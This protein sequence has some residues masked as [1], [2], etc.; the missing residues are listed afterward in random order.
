MPKKAH[1]TFRVATHQNKKRIPDF[2]LTVKQ[3]SLIMMQDGYSGHESIIHLRLVKQNYLV[4]L[5][6]S[7]LIKY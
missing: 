3:F 5:K 4:Y 1:F 6:T 7:H 2:P